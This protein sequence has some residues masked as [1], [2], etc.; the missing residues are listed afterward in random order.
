MSRE[1]RRNSGLYRCIRFFSTL[2]AIEEVFHVINGAVAVAVRRDNRILVPWRAFTI[3]AESTTSKLQGRVSAAELEAAVVDRRTHHSL[4]HHIK[5][6][7]AVRRLDG[8]GTIPRIE[9]IFVC[10]HVSP[11]W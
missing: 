11:A 6:G 7:I 8:V 4:I 10:Q 5:I 9:N 2:D 3:D 1:C